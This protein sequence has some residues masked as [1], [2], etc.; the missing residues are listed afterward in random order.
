MT[1]KVHRTMIRSHS[2]NRKVPIAIA[3]DDKATK[4]VL[5]PFVRIVR[6][7]VKA[8][9]EVEESQRF[10]F[11]LEKKPSVLVNDLSLLLSDSFKLH[12]LI[13]QSVDVLK[14]VTKACAASLYMIDQAHDQIYLS[15]VE[16][17]PGRL[18]LAWK[19]KESRMVA[20]Y[21]AFHKECV[22]CDDII[23]DKRF[24]E[25]VGY[26]SY[27]LILTFILSKIP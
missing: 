3:I 8:H 14:L 24:P 26:Q 25:G 7:G 9:A 13:H 5:A 17:I 12:E 6:K 27:Y 23:E 18:K 21:V 20:T 22:L 16:P 2:E 4:R 11:Y 1:T 15:K 19:I 10:S